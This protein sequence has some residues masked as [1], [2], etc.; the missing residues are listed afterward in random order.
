MLLTTGPVRSRRPASARRRANS[1]GGKSPTIMTV[2]APQGQ[3]GGTRR[4]PHRWRRTGRRRL[5]QH[6]LDRVESQCRRYSTRDRHAAELAARFPPRVRADGCSRC[7]R[8]A[9][10]TRHPTR[11][12]RS[13]QEERCASVARIATTF[14]T[15]PEAREPGR[16]VRGGLRHRRREVTDDL[17][18][19]PVHARGRLE[20]SLGD[21]LAPDALHRRDG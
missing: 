21:V 7:A 13:R 5:L 8:C 4:G 3:A 18:V 15:W 19:A 2:R 6:A 1:R 12:R 14:E 20:I 10:R 9:G 11:A 16:F 17:R